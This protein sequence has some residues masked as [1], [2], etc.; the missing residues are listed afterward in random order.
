L[1]SYDSFIEDEQVHAFRF[2][3]L[4]AESA[5]AIDVGK[6]SQRPY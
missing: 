4:S 2:Y 6:W 3:S 1:H 5:R